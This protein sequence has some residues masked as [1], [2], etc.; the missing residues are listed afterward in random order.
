MSK[1]YKAIFQLSKWIRKGKKNQN[2]KID[3]A[4]KK[5][6]TLSI[7]EINKE[8]NVEIASVGEQWSSELIQD[9]KGS[10]TKE[11]FSSQ[12]KE[13]SLN[14]EEMPGKWKNIYKPKEYIQ[15]GIYYSVNENITEEE[16]AQALILQDDKTLVTWSQ[17]KVIKGATRK[18]RKPIWFKHL[19]SIVLQ[20]LATRKIKDDFYT[21]TDLRGLAISNLQCLTADRRIKDWVITKEIDSE[22][23]LGHIIKKNSNSVLIEHWKE[24]DYL[25]KQ[26]ENI[27]CPPQGCSRI[28]I[29]N[30]QDQNESVAG[31]IEL[32]SVKDLEIELNK[33]EGYSR[34]KWNN[35]VD[36]IAKKGAQDNNI[37]IVDFQE[38]LSLR[39]LILWKNYLLDSPIR[40][41]L[42]TIEEFTAG[43]EWLYSSQIQDLEN[44]LIN[45]NFL[46]PNL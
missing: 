15:E 10:H 23:I 19:E 32:M 6:M 41:M 31:I 20:N 1:T 46:W 35:L 29:E 22:P 14:L 34:N 17:L 40:K 11:H 5:E 9:L 44:D 36:S 7:R 26:R 43:I 8:L 24:L 18:G 21:S 16:W 25:D 27:G 30:D 2:Q 37:P 33:I 12:F 13:K 38:I 4:L 42:Q 39:V 45:T 3:T 28:S